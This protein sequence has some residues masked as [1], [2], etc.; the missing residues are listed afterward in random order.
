[1]SLFVV[2]ALLIS[3]SPGPIVL[4]PAI[5][6]IGVLAS[7]DRRITSTPTLMPLTAIPTVELL[8]L[9]SFVVTS[10]G[11]LSVVSRPL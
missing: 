2:S 8:I 4:T 6:S 7:L 1:M 3:I 5:I 9:T 10:L 11:A